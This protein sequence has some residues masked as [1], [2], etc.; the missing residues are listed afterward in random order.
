MFTEEPEID[1]DAS[2]WNDW[3]E[4]TFG[5][6]DTEDN[7]R[8]PDTLGGFMYYCCDKR[9]DEPGGCMLGYH[10]AVDGKRGRYDIGNSVDDVDEEDVDEEDEEHDDEE[11]KEEDE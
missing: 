9:A 6:R 8:N 1:D 11:E 4:D 5:E 10:R 2:T 7:R 3:D